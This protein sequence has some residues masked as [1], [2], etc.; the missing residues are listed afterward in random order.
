MIPYK[1][2][3]KN[4]S[5]V[6][7]ARWRQ[8]LQLLRAGA[9]K[10][11]VLAQTGCNAG[12]I[13][14]SLDIQAGEI[15]VIMGLSGSG[16]STLVR[17]FNRLIDPSAGEILVD[18]RDVLAMPERELRALRRHRISM[19]FQGFGLMPHQTVLENAAFALLTRGEPKAQARASAAA[20]LARVGL[21]GYEDKYPDELS[22]GMRQRVGLARALAAD[23]DVLLMDEA[24]S[25]LDPLIRDDMQD[26]LLALQATLHKTII[27]ITHDL[28][29]ALK[30]G[31]RIAILRDG[32]L[33]QVGTPDE[34]LGAPAD[35]YVRKFVDKRAQPAAL[36]A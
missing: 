5:K 31:D 25:A 8:G 3:V 16:K 4:V 32:K 17:H 12:L 19:V 2:Q 36:P 29:E 11:E 14:V 34:I 7:G 24:F 13:D 20:W 10:A 26:Q 30:L 1:I 18:G 15:F 35:D 6:F 33:V 21:R 9:S 22:G 28:D 27:F 23:T